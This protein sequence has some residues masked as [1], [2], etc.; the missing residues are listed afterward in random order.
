MSTLA[1]QTID[2]QGPSCLPTE[3]QPQATNNPTSSVFARTEDVPVHNVPMRVINRPLPSELDENKVKTFMTEMERG[4]SFTPIEVVKV[5]A[6]LKTDPT[7]TPQVFYFAMG[8]CHRYE[9]TKRLGWETIRARII[10]VPANQM[11]IYLGAG[12]PF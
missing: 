4:D 3:L 2:T 8:G 6:P 11:R 10:D 12:S 5:K 1:Q 9:A 7:G